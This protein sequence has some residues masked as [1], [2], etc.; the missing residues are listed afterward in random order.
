MIEDNRENH[1]CQE[2]IKEKVQKEYYKRVRE[3]LKSKQNSE[4]VINAIIMW[5][6]ATFR[7]GDGIISWN[8][9]ELDKIDQQT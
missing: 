5:A 1:L 8:K 6:V 4:N 9:E 7:Y 2:K 3:M